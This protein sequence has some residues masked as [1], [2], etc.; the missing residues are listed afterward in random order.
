M[1]KIYSSICE[2]DIADDR[3]SQL[4]TDVDTVTRM[5][6]VCLSGGLS[7]SVTLSAL[8]TEA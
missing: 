3:L 2:F 7:G 8:S 6:T 4:I 1:L 5:F